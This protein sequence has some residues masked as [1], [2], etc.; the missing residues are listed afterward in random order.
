MRDAKRT[1][2][3]KANHNATQPQ[4]TTFVTGQPLSPSQQRLVAAYLAARGLTVASLAADW[5]AN[6]N[7]LSET[8]RGVRVVS[9]ALA[10]R[11]L[12]LLDDA[13]VYAE[14]LAADVRLSRQ[15]P[16][17]SATTC[18]NDHDEDLPF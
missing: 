17:P 2:K 12:V 11:L 6:R 5:Q 16:L 13:V 18:R 1:A 4:I 14:R 3:H 7:H 9:D 15:T 10:P 8:L